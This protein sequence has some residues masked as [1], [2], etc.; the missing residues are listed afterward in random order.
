MLYVIFKFN[1]FPAQKLLY[2]GMFKEKPTDLSHASHIQFDKVSFKYRSKQ[3]LILENIS[4]SVEP[5]Q[6]LSI[7]GRSGCGK[8]TLLQL[9]CG[10]LSPTQ[11]EVLIDGTRVKG[12]SPKWNMMFQEASLYPWMT[13]FENA[14]L[15]LR[16]NGKKKKSK[17]IV[18]PLLDLVGLSEF[19]DQNVQKL[20]GG[21]QQRVALARSLAT[22]PSAL[23]LDEPFSSLDVVT[24]NELQREVR[25]ITKKLQITLVTVTHD[26]DESLVLGDRVLAMKPNP[27]RVV[28]LFDVSQSAE[29]ERLTDIKKEL[30]D[31][32][33]GDNDDF[34]QKELLPDG[35][36][37]SSG[38]VQN[39]IR[40]AINAR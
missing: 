29:H 9:A 6:S 3:E 39:E 25:D 2:E 40:T 16:F 33:S 18:L 31:I 21:Q 23:F 20:S 36:H 10:M 12:M 4:F 15:G 5:A 27:G 26:L 17:E 8:S 19:R 1:L 28:Q 32:L 34:Q 22:H 7:I 24:R 14:S 35:L 13:V 38:T 11:G 30:L 37:F